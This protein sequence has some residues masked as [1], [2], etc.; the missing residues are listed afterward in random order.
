MSTSTNVDVKAPLTSL[1]RFIFIIC[2]ALSTDHVAVRR[3]SP[4]LS[5]DARATILQLPSHTHHSQLYAYV[6]MYTFTP[7]KVI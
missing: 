3:I 1:K 5:K 4:T 2:I 7:Q 6:H